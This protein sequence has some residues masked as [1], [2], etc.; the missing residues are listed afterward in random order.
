M[1]PAASIVPPTVTRPTAPL[2]AVPYP[3]YH[4]PAHF[5]LPIVHPPPMPVGRALASVGYGSARYGIPVA[6]PVLATVAKQAVE[7]LDEEMSCLSTA[8]SYRGDAHSDTSNSEVMECSN[9][10]KSKSK[11]YRTSIVPLDVKFQ[12]AYTDAMRNLRVRRF[13][14]PSP[15]CSTKVKLWMVNCEFERYRDSDTEEE[16]DYLM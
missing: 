10:I 15:A 8:E 16:E 9:E 14:A 11:V 5:A 7:W 4:R 13:S 12:T 1:P 2:G 6:H 3:S